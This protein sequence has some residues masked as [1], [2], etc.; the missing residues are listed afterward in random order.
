MSLSAEILADLE[1]GELDDLFEPVRWNLSP[2]TAMVEPAVTIDG[3]DSF[4]GPVLR[5]ERQFK[6]RRR[7]LEAIKVDFRAL[8]AVVTYGAEIYDVRE[9]E[10]RP[11]HPMV[12]VR[13]ELRP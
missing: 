10:N 12:V 13:G 2:T 11:G 6:F 3:M 5:G 7:D 8:G 9:I 1:S 4:G